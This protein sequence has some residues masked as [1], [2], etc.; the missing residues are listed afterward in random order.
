MKI[1]TAETKVMELRDKES[2]KTEIIIKNQTIDQMNHF[3]CLNNDIFYDK[4]CEM[5][6][7]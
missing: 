2:V 3:I 1:F 4:D 7:R 5:D 6:I